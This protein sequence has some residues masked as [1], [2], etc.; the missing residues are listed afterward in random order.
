MSDIG[1]VVV[2]FNQVS[3]EPEVRGPLYDDQRIAAAEADALR[4]STADIGRRERY[5]V[6]E[7]VLIEDPA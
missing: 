5:A 4:A 7:V 2:E 3:H 6:A 1:Y